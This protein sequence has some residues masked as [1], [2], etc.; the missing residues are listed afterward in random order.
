M[1]GS[2]VQPAP[3]KGFLERLQDGVVVGDG[4]MG[5]ML[6][7]RGVFVNRCFDELNLSNPALVR[8]VHQEYLEAGA[9]IV[10]TNTFG[11]HRF[12]LGPHGFEH[13]VRKI[14]REGAR[15]A[16]E[17]AQGRG[18]VAGSV[19]P[20]GKPLEPLGNIA[21][22]EAV[23]AYREQAEGLA[24]GGVDLFA[25]ETIPA[26]D[27]A[28]AAVT[29][30]RAVSTLPITVSMTFTEEGTTFY[31]D[32]P[33]DIVRTLEDWDVSVAGANCSQGPQPMLETVQRMASVARRLKLSA[34]PNAGAPAMVD[35]RYVYL[36]TPEYMA[37]Y[38]RRFIAAGVTVVGG[39]CGTTPAH[40]RNLVRSVRMVQPAREVLT[41]VPPA[42]AKEALPPVPR[43]EKSA[44]AR[45]L[46]KK[47]VVSVE[48]DPPKG[49]DAG[50]IIDRAQYCKENEIDAINVADGPRASARMSAQSL[51][52]LLQNK[53]G[54]DTILHYTCRDRNLLG[55]QSDLL[56]AYALGLRNI[57]AIT[58]DPPKLGDYPDATAVYDVD[59]IG[60]IR[61][62]DHLNH[63]CDLAGNLIGPAL[64][65]H[66]GCGADPSKP[67]M[68]KEVRRLEEKVKAGAEYVMTQPVYD[69]STV[70]RFLS[71][72]KHLQVPIMIGILPLYS[73]R[74]AEFLHNEVPGMRIPD[75]IRER[76]HT[77]GSGEKA[78]LEGVAIAQEALLAAR[79]LAQGAYIM[80]PFNKVELA[81]RVIEPLG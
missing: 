65:I 1:S 47:F 64:G 26:L 69:P 50:R 71:A 42:A 52:V 73:H 74:N 41:I 72:V 63:G 45:S 51:C 55:I 80:P 81:V 33:E 28:R 58:G 12:K 66:V 35:G 54:I 31:G 60:L 10:E 39:C 70:E 76:M 2:K 46:G 25:V 38:A 19:G 23:A 49:A 9:D 7:A 22:D 48:L 21:F 20:L 6:Y 57:L 11:A 16:R 14:N 24:E 5:T 32:K 68:E 44:L 3:V 34:M 13:Q 8:S 62:M 27:Q 43:E 40:I 15:L 30:I 18:L 53:V 36:C 4:A 79:E 77:A 78:Q 67:D 61:I 59:S 37:S 17:A 56:G 29:A 75:D